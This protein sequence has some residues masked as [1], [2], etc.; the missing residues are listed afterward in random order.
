MLIRP[1]VEAKLLTCCVIF[2]DG[3]QLSIPAACDL[4]TPIMMVRQRILLRIKE[5][6]KGKEIKTLTIIPAT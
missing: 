3:T 5:T 2:T 4:D 1:T 6:N